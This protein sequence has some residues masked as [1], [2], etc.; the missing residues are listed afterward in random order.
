MEET[1]K[2]SRWNAKKTMMVVVMGLLTAIIVVLQ[3]FAAG[4]QLGGLANITLVL[5]P[6]IVGA[7]LYGW[8]AGAWLGLVFGAVVLFSGQAGLFMAM[9]I[10]GTIIT[11]LLKGALAGA[12]GG[13]MY[14]LIQKKNRKAAV[15]AAGV[16]T[17]VVNTGVYL[18][19]CL[20]FFMD[21]LIGLAEASKY[22]TMF[23]YI[24]FVVIGTNFIVELAV[25]L[26][27]SSAIVLI[28]NIAQKKLKI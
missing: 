26:I 13:L 7:A 21:Y 9:S 8:K 20:V 11:V 18:L 6:I 10:P 23:A 16:V 1:K 15:V 2:V 5:A 19:G 22:N 28:L 27:L 12:A 24:L 25:N 3:I 17:P 14:R 4:I